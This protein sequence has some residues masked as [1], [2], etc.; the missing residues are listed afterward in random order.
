M[1]KGVDQFFDRLEGAGVGGDGQDV[2]VFERDDFGIFVQEGSDF[3]AYHGGVGGFQREK[4]RFH[5]AAA[6]LGTDIQPL[7]R[8]FGRFD[9]FHEIPLIDQ[10]IAPGCEDGVGQAEQRAGLDRLGG[11][12][13]DF[14]FEVAVDEDVFLENLPDHGDEIFDRHVADVD[15]DR[16]FSGQTQRACQQDEHDQSE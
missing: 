16:L 6:D 12:E 14:A 1:L 13:I 2:V 9:H 7:S 3:G 10:G 4:D 15:I 8:C 11:D 5:C